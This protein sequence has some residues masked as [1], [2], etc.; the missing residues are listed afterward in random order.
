MKRVII[1]FKMKR[2]KNSKA[3]EKNTFLELENKH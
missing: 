3:E 1:N 2:S